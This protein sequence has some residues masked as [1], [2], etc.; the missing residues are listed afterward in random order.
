MSRK[1]I[2]ELTNPP[3]LFYN[4][5]ESKKYHMNSRIDRIQREITERCLELLPVREKREMIL[6]IGCGSGISTEAIDNYI[7]SGE[8]NN[9]DI[10]TDIN[11]D[12]PDNN[13]TDNN[14]SDNNQDN[15]DVDLPVL[16]NAFIIGLDISWDM[17]SLTQP[18]H[19]FFLSDIG[20]PWPL[21]DDS[22]D[23]AIS[24]SVVQWLFHSYKKEDEPL[25]RIRMFFSELHRVVKHSSV[26][27]FYTTEK[28]TGIFLKMAKRV[29]FKGGMQIDGEGTK[30]EKKYLI[31]SK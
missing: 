9:Q 14:D 26:L 22:I 7:E 15:S 1:K 27:Q 5:K 19:S 13:A 3:E 11:N 16:S 30:K 20:T 4:E 28:Q 6:D 8:N 23:Y 21:A 12:V 31:L 18:D 29:G 10:N 17:L 24:A 25:E 2:P